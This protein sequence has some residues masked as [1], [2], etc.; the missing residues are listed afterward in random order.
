ML[1]V[2]NCERLWW[3][4]EGKQEGRKKRRNEEG[5]EGRGMRKGKECGWGREGWKRNEEGKEGRGMRKGKE[6]GWVREGDG[7]RKEEGMEGRRE[8]YV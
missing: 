7:M 3:R 5:K 2:T 8:G 4:E 1:K 6:C